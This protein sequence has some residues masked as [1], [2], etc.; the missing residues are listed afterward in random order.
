MAKT[1]NKAAAA[2][3]RAPGPAARLAALEGAVAEQGRRQ[4]HI[5]RA[6][7]NL[8]GLVEKLPP[9]PSEVSV[10]REGFLAGLRNLQREIADG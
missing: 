1:A 9:M 3:P 6:L 10:E 5:A 2:R 8:K 4:G 7:L